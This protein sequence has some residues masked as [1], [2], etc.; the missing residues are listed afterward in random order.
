MGAPPPWL[1]ATNNAKHN[2]PAE[3]QE[4]GLLLTVS[5]FRFCQG[6]RAPA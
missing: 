5:Q 6:N 2:T 4:P 1:S 3:G